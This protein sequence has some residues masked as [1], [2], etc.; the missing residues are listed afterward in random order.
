MA[1][2]EVVVV[3]TVLEEELLQLALTQEEEEAEAFAVDIR[4]ASMMTLI[5]IKAN[6]LEIS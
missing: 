1:E 2:K 4:G 6:A 3:D 5:Y